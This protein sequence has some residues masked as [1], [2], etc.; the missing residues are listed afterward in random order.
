MIASSLISNS[1]ESLKNNMTIEEARSIFTKNKLHHLPLIDAEN[2]VIGIISENEIFSNVE[3]QNTIENLITN[4]FSITIY[5]HQHIFEIFEKVFE[6][7]LTCIPVIDEKNKY[8][9]LITTTTLISYFSKIS[10]LRVAGAIIVLEVNIRDYTLSKIAQIV[11]ENNAKILSLYSNSNIDSSQIE[12]TLKLNIHEISG[13]IQ[14]F[15]RFDYTVKTFYEGYNKLFD[16]YQD[17]IDSLMSY[18]KV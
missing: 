9:G 11:E 5:S 12:I 10:S 2:N 16:L 7:N 1:I 6:N 17:R 18:L 15:E 13:I 3:L 4:A 8:L 14:H